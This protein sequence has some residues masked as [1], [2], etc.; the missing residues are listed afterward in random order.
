MKSEIAYLLFKDAIEL[1]KIFQDKDRRFYGKYMTKFRAMRIR[2]G[3]CLARENSAPNEVYFLL[4]GCIMRESEEEKKR[5]IKNTYLIEG[6]I[7]GECDVLV[8]RPRCESYTAMA[9]CYVLGLSK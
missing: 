5:G 3:T 8:N 1:I 4:A 6:S 2:E 7:F 9:D